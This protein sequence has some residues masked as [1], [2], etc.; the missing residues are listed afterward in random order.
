MKR[1][2]EWQASEEVA[3]I[4]DHKRVSIPGGGGVGKMG[5]GPLEAGGIGP[6]HNQQHLPITAGH[7][8]STRGVEIVYV[9]ARSAHNLRHFLEL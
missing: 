4:L 1:L 9:E 7:P 2:L 8:T 3:K 5:A 6:R